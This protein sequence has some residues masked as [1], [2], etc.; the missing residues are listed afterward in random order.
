MGCDIH[1]Y[2]EVR[3][4]GVWEKVGDVFENPYYDPER[5]T[6]TDSNGYTWNAKYIDKPYDD[7]NYRLFAILANVRNDDDW[8]PISMPR[9]IPKDISQEIKT[10]VDD[11]N[12]DGHS[13]SFF[14]LKEL[15]EFDWDKVVGKTTRMVHEDTYKKFMETGEKPDS[16]CAWTNIENWKK[17]SW[18][19]TYRE[20]AGEYFFKILED[21]KKLGDQENVR[22]VF[23]F[24]N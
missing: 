23:W 7:R 19:T 16:W 11:W 8:Q 6:R 20:C 5:P 14:T 17:L 18:E 15:L 9:G 22:I 1:M 2:A 4:N 24:D 10:R 21:M 12:G 13:H 3:K